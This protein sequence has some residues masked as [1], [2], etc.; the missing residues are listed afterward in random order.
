MCCTVHVPT[1][2]RMLYMYVHRVEEEYSKLKRKFMQAKEFLKEK[3]HENASDETRSGPFLSHLII[4]STAT[5]LC[6]V[7]CTSI[8]LLLYYSHAVQFSYVLLF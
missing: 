4:S 1:L 7:L 2:T 3:L 5:I 8:V 6:T